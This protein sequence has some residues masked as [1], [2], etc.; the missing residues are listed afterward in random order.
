MKMKSEEFF[1]LTAYWSYSD[2]VSYVMEDE[3]WCD[4]IMQLVQDKWED[5]NDF[6]LEDINRY[7]EEK[8]YPQQSQLDLEG[9]E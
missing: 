8:G 4:A 3:R 7:A 9:N 6:S 2:I 1:K 5:E